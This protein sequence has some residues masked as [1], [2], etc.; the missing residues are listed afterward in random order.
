MSRPNSLRESLLQRPDN[1]VVWIT[2]DDR[3][4]LTSDLKARINKVAVPTTRQAVAID[5]NHP[6]SLAE[7]LLHLDGSA[8]AIFL[9][10][11]GLDSAQKE[12]LLERAGIDNVL[13]DAPPTNAP[14][15]KPVHELTTRWVLATSGTTGE[16]KLIEHTFAT[17]TRSAK[18]DTSVGAE[19]VWTSLYNLTGFAG[20]QV[21][22]QAWCGGST[23]L[24][25][26][27]NDSIETRLERMARF[28][29]TAL[30]A[31]PTMWR[32]ILMSHNATTV[33]LKRIT[34][35]GE[36][37][38]Q[39]VL[40]AL[41]EAYPNA[42]ITHI[43][44]STEA[45]VGF[46]VRDTK[47]GF[48][49]S[50]LNDAPAGI[51]IRVVGDRLFL[52]PEKP[53]SDRETGR[54]L[55][56][57]EGFIDTGDTVRRVDDRYEFLGRAN[58]AINVGGNKVQ[59]EEVERVLL[60]CPGVEQVRV[61]AKSSPFTGSLVV[62]DVVADPTRSQDDIRKSVGTFCRANLEA[63]KVPAIIKFV[64]Q[65]ETTASGKMKRTG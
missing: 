63:Y 3:R 43:Y 12:K 22:L 25:D 37:A 15:T 9:L 8:D 6:E 38:D 13:T 49:A 39:N 59:P 52:R 7:C 26:R 47:S 51:T 19:H 32:K 11:P 29:V 36:I 27:P 60:D 54:S 18:F 45:G 50:F 14:S 20:L 4:V 40:D 30:S 35:G 62:A 34:L 17:L 16:P 1:Q 44:A 33:P 53:A 64:A 42:K 56:N 28:K 57:E 23:F 2:P 10:P 55:A 41:S 5:A 31:T 61:Y 24:M 65:I 46:S 48:P 21:F 58:G